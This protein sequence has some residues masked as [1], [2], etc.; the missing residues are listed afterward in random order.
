MIS[1]TLIDDLEDA[2]ASGSREKRLTTLRRVTD[3]FVLGAS[4]YTDEQ[5][6]VFGD[7][8]DR[9]ARQI[10][11][12]ARAQ[13][14]KRLAPIAN[15]P[16]KVIQ[17]LA[18]DDVIDVAGPVLAESTRLSD[19][20]LIDYAYA[21][22]Q[23]H[24]LAISKRD[25]LSEAV[26]DV[27][28]ERGDTEVVRSV[29]RNEGARFSDSG[30]GILVK[31]SEGDDVLAEHVGLRQ[32]LPRHHL[33]GLLVKASG[34]VLK[35]L[36]KAH[37]HLAHEVEHVLQGITGRIEAE[38]ASHEYADAK[39]VV[40]AL[41]RGGELGEE[42]ILTFTRMGRQKEAMVALS[43]L[44]GVP[45]EGIERA[46]LDDQTD[47]VLIAAKAAAFSWATTK[48]FVVMQASGRG[49]SQV[50]LDRIRQSFER[51]QVATAQRVVRFYQVRQGAAKG[52]A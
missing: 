10:E 8:I 47:M 19:K 4:Q 13:L 17:A 26:T 30:F 34:N 22:S 45:I 6:G 20:E 44:S 11:I 1:Q 9:L 48:A 33:H 31:R 35:K 16:I 7:V 3:L 5:V 15:A 18:A 36:T 50:D 46:M 12:D 14:A 38:A 42:Q 2:I 28:V 27:L 40:E 23:D 24:L 49:F 52:V 29:A 43:V 41:H 21:K 51:L 32:D 39:I 25:S 37:P